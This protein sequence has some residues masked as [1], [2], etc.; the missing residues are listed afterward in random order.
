MHNAAIADHLAGWDQLARGVTDHAGEVPAPMLS[1]RDALVQARKKA[2]AA[3]QR[4]AVARAAAQKATRELE[5]AMEEAHEAATR[6]RSGLWAHYGRTSAH[7]IAFGM[8]PY[9]RAKA[10]V[11]DPIRI[12]GGPLPNA[13]RKPTPP[14]PP[15]EAKGEPS[16]SPR[17]AEDRRGTVP[18]RESDS[19][20]PRG[21]LV[22]EGERLPNDRRSPTLS[23]E[24]APRAR[25]A[26]ER[27]GAFPQR[28]RMAAAAAGEGDLSG[29]GPSGDG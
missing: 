19:P 10:R 24:V 17:E 14:A 18:H 27:G 11:G 8:R 9:P 22:D 20:A 13:V 1:Q 5:A 23:L 7:L 3:L 26:E 4:Q 15:P 16:P 6:I 29:S 2:W 12:E 25:E 28:D 21:E